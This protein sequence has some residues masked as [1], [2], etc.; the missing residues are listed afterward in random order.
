MQNQST[1]GN[2]KM[3]LGVKLL[4]L[5]LFVTPHSKFACTSNKISLFVLQDEK[6]EK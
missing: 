2:S 5:E 3:V 1:H 4:V 6:T